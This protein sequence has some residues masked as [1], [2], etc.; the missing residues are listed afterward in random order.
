MPL[1]VSVYLRAHT[2]LPVFRNTECEPFARWT[3]TDIG[4]PIES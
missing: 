1:W 3:E 4:A 2:M